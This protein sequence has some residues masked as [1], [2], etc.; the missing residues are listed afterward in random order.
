[1]ISF[2][3]YDA[4]CVVMDIGGDGYRWIADSTFGGEPLRTL[5]EA[6]RQGGSTDGAKSLQLLSL[7]H[8]KTPGYAKTA[9]C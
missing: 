2:A 9:P 7:K 3:T 1:M 6:A 5:G 4:G 8:S